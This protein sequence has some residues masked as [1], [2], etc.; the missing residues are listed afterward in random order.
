MVVGN[1]QLAKAFRDYLDDDSICI[2][3]SGVANSTCTHLSE[4]NREKELLLFHLKNSKEK[5][6]IYFSSCALS[7][8]EYPKNDYYRHKENME[9]LIQQ[10]SDNYY[11]FR[12]PQL[13]GELILH[14]T[15]INFFYKCIEHN[16]HFSVYSGAYRY[17]IEIR[18]VKTLVNAYLKYSDSCIIKDL[19][20]PYRYS[21]LE[22]VKTFEVI[23]NKEANYNLVEKDD[24]YYLEF[25]SMQSFIQ[26]YNLKLNFS[27]DYLQKKLM[28][29]IK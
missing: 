13:F 12:I 8:K 2:F 28:E 23:M 29:K 16:H 22:I 15:L 10:Y 11:I 17:L 5:K 25:Q 20:N 7:A 24:N 4:F 14:K 27:V 3:A 26:K 6:F 9:N 21:I 1:G 18:D 19:G